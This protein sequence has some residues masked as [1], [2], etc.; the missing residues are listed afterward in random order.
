M[1]F[2]KA[3]FLISQI[4]RKIIKDNLY[5]E[6]YKILCAIEKYDLYNELVFNIFIQWDQIKYENNIGPFIIPKIDINKPFPQI[7]TLFEVLDKQITTP[8]IKRRKI[9]M[10]YKT[11]KEWNKYMRYICGYFNI[12]RDILCKITMKMDQK[13]SFYEYKEISKLFLKK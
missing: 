8:L 11:I 2:Y 7:I 3:L 10:K 12:D 6:S 5:I 1:L 9:N 4:M 13:I